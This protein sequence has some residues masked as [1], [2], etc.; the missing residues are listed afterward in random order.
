MTLEKLK[1][2]VQDYHRDEPSNEAAL[3]GLE[4]VQSDIEMLLDCIRDDI[5][6]ESKG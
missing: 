3:A 4:E 2:A 1:Q 6:R 5:G